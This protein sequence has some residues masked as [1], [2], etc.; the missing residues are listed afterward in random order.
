MS[1]SDVKVLPPFSNSDHNSIT[2]TLITE[3]VPRGDDITA[4]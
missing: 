1:C 3:R 4:Q 2:F